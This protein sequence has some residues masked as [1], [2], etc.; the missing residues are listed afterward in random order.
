[1]LRLPPIEASLFKLGRFEVEVLGCGIWAV[2]FRLKGL[3]VQV[4]GCGVSA[5]YRFKGF[6]FWNVGFRV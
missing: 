3:R 4:L 2:G 1:M 5:A 6:G